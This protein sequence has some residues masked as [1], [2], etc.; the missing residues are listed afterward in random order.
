MF[1]ILSLYRGLTCV[2]GPALK[3]YL[4]KRLARGKEHAAR[5][6]E[7]LGQPSQPR[8]P[9]KLL[10]VHGASNGEL[11]S[12]VPLLNALLTAHPEWQALVTSGTVTSSATF[13]RLAPTL[14]PGRVTHQ[15]IPVDHPRW[16]KQFM[17]HWRPDGVVW[18]ESELW[19]NLLQAIK[20]RRIPAVLV[21]A[22]MRPK[23]FKRWQML[24]S[25]AHEMLS[26]FQSVLVM[27][28]DMVPMFTALG[29]QNVLAMGNLKYA[30]PPA[31][32]DPVKLAA[33][34][35][36]IGNRLCIGAFSTHATDEALFTQTII[37]LKSDHPDVLGIV[38][39][40][41]ATRL[42]DI[43]AE[44]K[45]M[46]VTVAVRSRQEPITAHTDIYIADTRGEMGLWHNL[47]E[48]GMIGG[49]F[50]PHGGQNPFECTH[51][52]CVPVYGPHMFNFTDMINML[53]ER[54]ASLPVADKTQ[55][56]PALRDLLQNPA[57]LADKQQSA[58]A[59]ADDCRHVIEPIAALIATRVMTA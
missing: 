38:A 24:Q 47:C 5:L 48:M 18:L 54:N 12:A 4:H 45:T 2:S 51:T 13:E 26:T 23:T 27:A 46:G 56:Y 9:G 14:P 15:F 3:A 29:A 49:S 41:H 6:P 7:R 31:A 32:C 8:P 33:L 11:M 30:N 43:E 17:D 40:H 1:N 58:R 25:A 35:D 37:Q 34:Q 52:G 42:P 53:E 55:L 57:Q 36:M 44:L 22:R 28:S 16:V 19:P 21:N 39:P 10:W 59:M 20:T 50:F